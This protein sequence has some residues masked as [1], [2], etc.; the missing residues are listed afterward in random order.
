MSSD[1]EFHVK[2]AAGSS[3]RRNEVRYDQAARL[4]LTDLLQ[5]C[6]AKSHHGERKNNKKPTRTWLTTAPSLFGECTNSVN[7]PAK[8][9]SPLP[10]SLLVTFSGTMAP[11]RLSTGIIDS[12][13]DTLTVVPPANDCD[14]L[15]KLYHD[16][17]VWKKAKDG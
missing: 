5:P 1:G 17:P 15:K 6:G 11:E 4:E 10:T 13:V 12:G 9:Q 16:E 7:E 8:L 2:Q 14:G 3:R